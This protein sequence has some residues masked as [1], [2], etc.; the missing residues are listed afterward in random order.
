VAAW[1]TQRT[2]ATKR[3]P[4]ENIQHRITHRIL[5]SG[6]THPDRALLECHQQTISPYDGIRSKILETVEHRNGDA[7]FADLFKQIREGR[8]R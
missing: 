8:I 4:P 1:R 3:V 5:E 2:D 7:L 6:E